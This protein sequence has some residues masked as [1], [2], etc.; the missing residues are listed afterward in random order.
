MENYRTS[1]SSTLT[2]LIAIVWL[3]PALLFAQIPGDTIWTHNYGMEGAD[4]GEAVRQTSDGGFIL[5]GM[6]VE[7]PDFWSYNFFLVK[8]DA[9]GNQVWSKYY[10]YGG[11]IATVDYAKDVQQTIDGGYIV[12]GS[13]AV[14]TN[15]YDIWLIK[16][17][18]NGDTMW[19]RT[20]GGS[21]SDFG[22]S[23]EQTSDGGYILTG[24]NQ[25][26]Q[27]YHNAYLVKTYANGN[28]AWDEEYGGNRTDEYG[29]CVTQTSDGGYI[30]VGKTNASG[31]DDVYVVKTNFTG[32]VEW[33]N[34]FGGTL[35]D[36]AWSVIENSDGDFMISGFTLSFGGGMRAYVLKVSPAGSLIWQK[37]YG[38][39]SS[40]RAA[41][42]AQTIDGGYAL[43]GG[44]GPTPADDFYV[45]RT[46]SQGT[47]IW[48]RTYGKTEYREYGW[49]GC[50]ADDTVF[51]TIGH[52]NAFSAIGK[53]DFWLV[54]IN[55]GLQGEPR[56]A[57]CDDTLSICEDNVLQSQCTARFAPDTLC[58]DM[59]PPC[60][61]TGAGCDEDEILVKIM[62]DDFPEETTWEL[63]DKDDSL[64]ASGGPYPGQN[65]TLIVDTVCVDSLECYNFVIYDS[66]VNGITPPG[67]FEIYLNSQLVG[68]DYSFDGDSAFVSYVGSRCGGLGACCDDSLAECNMYV[69]LFDCGGGNRR[70][71]EYGFCDDFYPPCGGCP[72]DL[73]EIRIMTDYGPDETTWELRN[74]SNI[75]VAQGGPYPEQITLFTDYV[76]ADSIGC[77]SF[78]IFDSYGDGLAPP[79]YF[80][81]YLNGTLLESNNT[82]YGFSLTIPRLGDDCGPLYGACCDDTTADCNENIEEQNCQEPSMRF[83]PNGTCAAFNPP[84][85][86]CPEDEIVI[87]IMPDDYPNE[88]SWIL[89][90]SGTSYVVAYGGPLNA[91]N[92]L[93]QYY[94]CADPDSCYDFYIFDT[95]GDGICCDYGIGY[96][97]I[98]SNGALVD[99]GGQF[100]AT[101][102]V[103]EISCPV[104]GA[105]CNDSTADCN[106]NIEEQ[107]CQ[108]PT[109]RFIADGRCEDFDPPCGDLILGACCDDSTGDCNEYIEEQNCQGPTMRFIAF[110]RC[111]DFDPPC[112][113]PACD[114][115]VGDVNG[116]D[117]YNGLDITYGVAFFKGGAAPLYECECTPG[118]IW[119]VSGDVNGS[120]NYNG[121]DITYGVAYFKGGAA[122]FPCPDCPPNPAVSISSDSGKLI[123]NDLD[124]YN[125][126]DHV[127]KIKKQR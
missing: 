51:M 125:T 54:A 49:G 45:V 108:G 120:C 82:F 71:I 22:W 73:F 122:P 1:M 30:L 104:F 20:F 96:Y 35:N 7:I 9:V 24:W 97:R 58:V 107:D 92:T 15:E 75:I 117:N 44:K 57:C 56:G 81:I 3:L 61:G 29:N 105:C 34:T 110:G 112:G 4:W 103:L 48:E 114:Y 118:N 6:G 89:T 63:T 21:N 91:Y 127:K 52:S 69:D 39:S 11:D 115:V 28:L 124:S 77:Y 13:A 64:I 68:A 80:E 46:D 109:M 111:E 65:N 90:R 53:Y 83:M 123:R 41:E 25:G 121:L 18:A 31:N 101:D 78:T 100:G 72:E 5:C 32:G 70:F 26:N 106:E 62:T 12:T 86:G 126:G 43:F 33:E 116:S 37:N 119:Y 17:D 94:Y 42:I 40:Q 87:E 55:S 16:T 66:G 10:N 8:T 67:Y 38:I 99:S 50:I 76:C 98:Y 47:V 19:T 74:S 102:T 93:Y 36:E 95:A 2:Y 14:A 85:G 60:P 23:V 79:G 113:G 27:G 88:I 84:C 59:D